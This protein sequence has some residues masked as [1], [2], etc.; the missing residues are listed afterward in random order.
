MERPTAPP[1][2]TPPPCRADD[3]RHDAV[4]TRADN[5]ASP[6]NFTQSSRASVTT[7]R[8]DEDADRTKSSVRLKKSIVLQPMQCLNSTA[9][10]DELFYL[11]CQAGDEV[12]VRSQLP[13][14][15]SGALDLN[16]FTH[17]QDTPLCVAC[18]EERLEVVT[19]LLSHPSIQ[20]NLSNY[21]HPP[22]ALAAG[23]GRVQVVRLLLGHPAIDVNA[24][25]ARRTPLTAA[26]ENGHLDVVQEL[27]ACPA[28]SLNLLDH[29]EHS[30]LFTASLHGH[31][32]VVRFL[33]TLPDTD[34][35][36]LCGGDLAVTMA[37]LYHHSDIVTMLLAV[38]TLDV[39]KLDQDGHSALS[40]ACQEG[41]EDIV[42][43]L[44]THP[45]I[46]LR[47]SGTKSALTWAVEKGQV[48]I[49][50]RLLTHEQSIPSTVQPTDKVPLTTVAC[51][52][53][54]LDIVKLL[55]ARGVF[56]SDPPEVQWTSV[57][58]ALLNKRL[59][60]CRLLLVENGSK[61]TLPPTPK[62]Q[63]TLLH[64][65]AVAGY[66]DIVGTLLARAYDDVGALD[67]DGRTAL[68]VAVT[69]GQWG[70]ATLLLSADLPV[71]VS[72]DGQ[73]V[74]NATHVNSWT[75]IADPSGRFAHMDA[76][77]RCDV[78]RA[79]LL[80]FPESSQRELA[81]ALLSA[82][83]S[84]SGL[85]VDSF[86]DSKSLELLRSWTPSP[87]LGERTCLE[88]QRALRTPGAVSVGRVC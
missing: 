80:Q 13:L 32:D 39:N 45:A 51:Q 75:D 63:P 19:L 87:Q 77:K 25:T 46:Q 88:N 33:L 49:L 15:S 17:H 50:D 69:Q 1:E 52:R 65:A 74:P 85:T 38:P 68:E 20:V 44:L 81:Q 83:H 29:D 54:H 37:T 31:S 78:V 58:E 16:R 23:L 5:G 11:A 4:A 55:L 48:A 59:K 35:N 62:G 30:A 82:T 24:A 61:L 72:Q 9:S 21:S 36:L 60:V 40:L 34:V 18:V 14:A 79:L 70:V 6:E 43:L 64:A 84:T 42:A 26:C 86:I 10:T 27:C 3:G 8:Q 66:E 22:L 76:S 57:Y 47:V 73:V 41:F 2:T 71:R 28:L 7:P 56:E 67:P 53:G 12:M